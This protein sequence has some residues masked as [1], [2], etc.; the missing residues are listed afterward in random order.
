MRTY[1]PLGP[2]RQTFALRLRALLLVLVACT[3]PAASPQP[4]ATPALRIVVLEGEDAVNI[5]QQRTAIMSVVEVRDRNGQPVAGAVDRFELRTGPASVSGAGT[6]TLTTNA[7]GR[8][9]AEGLFPPDPGALQ[10]GA[11]ASDHGQ[12]TAVTIAQTNVATAAQAAAVGASAAGGGSTASA[13]ACVSATTIGII[14]TADAGVAGAA[15]R[16]LGAA[17]ASTAITGPDTAQFPLFHAPPPGAPR[18]PGSWCSVVWSRSGTIDYDYIEK[19]GTVQGNI[20][21]E[22]D[23]TIVASTGTGTEIYSFSGSM[24]S[25]VLT[26]PFSESE[27]AHLSSGETASGSFASPLTLR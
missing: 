11:T 8:A 21:D 7:T 20:C 24:A 26:G 17:T 4:T 2:V 16:I 23:R 14:P 15:T 19:N 6:P 13:G 27:R 18:S 10:L 25:G 3:A 5:I 9:V 12:A 22:T 1:P